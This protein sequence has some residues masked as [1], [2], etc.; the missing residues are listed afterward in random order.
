MCPCLTSDPRVLLPGPEHLPVLSLSQDWSPVLDR[1]FGQRWCDDVRG[2]GG[3]GLCEGSDLRVQPLSASPL[4]LEPTPSS[5][6]QDPRWTPL[7]DMEVFSPDPT[8]SQRRTGGGASSERGQVLIF[9][10][11]GG[12]WLQ[13]PTPKHRL[14][15]TAVSTAGSSGRRSSA[16]ML[17]RLLTL[18]SQLMEDDDE[19]AVARETQAAPASDDNSGG[20]GGV[21]PSSPAARAEEG[22]EEE[23]EDGRDKG[24]KVRKAGSRTAPVIPSEAPPPPRQAWASVCA[25]ELISCL[26]FC[27]GRG[28][29]SGPSVAN[30]AS[31][32]AGR[33]SSRLTVRL[34][35]PKTPPPR[36]RAPRRLA[37]ARPR[38]CAPPRVEKEAP[39]DPRLDPASKPPQ[40]SE[41]GRTGSG[42]IRARIHE[43]T[44]KL[45]GAKGTE[46]FVLKH[47]RKLAFFDNSTKQTGKWPSSPLLPRD[48]PGLYH[49]TCKK[50]L[51]EG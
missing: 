7:E 34:T 42:R 51:M 6:Q 26:C 29:G 43:T 35:S 37:T 38:R 15:R 27:R 50:K 48:S 30:V 8:G 49:L 10:S 13:F 12:S 18:P 19:A 22:E 44:T 32:S 33:L 16:S 28:G 25:S 23:E 31:G 9:S 20:Q 14:E 4:A 17:H 2:A 40:P 39:T 47:N 5:P 24:R 3:R 45:P 36:R 21:G 1:V 46:A 11:L 41:A